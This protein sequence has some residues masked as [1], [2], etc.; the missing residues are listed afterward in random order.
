MRWTPAAAPPKANPRSWPRTST[1][2]FS[3]SDD[4]VLMYHKAQPSVGR[5]LTWYD[6]S[7]KTAGTV[8]EAGEVRQPGAVAVGRPRRRGRL[9]QRQPR[10]LGDGPGP[11][12]DVPADLRAELRVD[13]DV[14]SGRHPDRRTA[15]TLA[16]SGKPGST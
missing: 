1:P 11:R 14:V 15:R 16:T 6:R 4:N 9:D 10:R 12:R 8:G 3:V 13:A 7:G 2:T 5:Q